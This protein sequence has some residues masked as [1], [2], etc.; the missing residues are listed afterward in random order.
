MEAELATLKV[1]PTSAVSF[2]TTKYEEEISK[3][4]AEVQS[5]TLKIKAIEEERTRFSDEFNKISEKLKESETEFNIKLSSMGVSEQC[6]REEIN[7]L[8]S[9]NEQLKS[10][11]CNKDESN[12]KEYLSMK[13]IEYELKEELASVQNELKIR[14]ASLASNDG[15][16]QKIIAEKDAIISDLKKLSAGI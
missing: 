2:D 8:T 16:L 12:E 7:F 14:D 15:E 4:Q 13:H 3:L 5:K 10:E 1:T 6:L 9:E 11:L